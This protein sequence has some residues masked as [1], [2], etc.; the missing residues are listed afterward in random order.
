MAVPRDQRHPKIL[1]DHHRSAVRCGLPVPRD[2][3]DGMTRLSLMISGRAADHSD[4]LV[5][6]RGTA[7]DVTG[8]VKQSTVNS[9]RDARLILLLWT[10][11]CGL[12]TGLDTANAV[13]SHQRRV[14]TARFAGSRWRARRQPGAVSTHRVVGS[15]ED[16]RQQ[17]LQTR[18]TRM[19][20]VSPS[21]S[22]DEVVRLLDE[23]CPAGACAD[24]V[25]RVVSNRST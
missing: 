8:K 24:A 11:A 15:S 21:N 19:I 3:E 5:L 13:A 14:E 10:V 12:S 4:R 20:P 2:Q 9:Q 18:R 17:Q 23:V 16:R 1:G 6:K 7:P 22:K 25:N